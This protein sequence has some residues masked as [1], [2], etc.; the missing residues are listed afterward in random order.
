MQVGSGNSLLAFGDTCCC[1]AIA[2]S[3]SVCCRCVAWSG[4]YPGAYR[5]WFFRTAV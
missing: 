1:E 5:D 4:D 2:V 3:G